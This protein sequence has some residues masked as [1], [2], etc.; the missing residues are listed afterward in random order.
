MHLPATPP[1]KRR[2]RER[3]SVPPSEM[4]LA[5]EPSYLEAG[6]TSWP[7]QI[8]SIDNHEKARLATRRRRRVPISA[9]STHADLES[10]SPTD[11]FGIV[12]YPIARATQGT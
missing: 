9:Q 4:E 1:T 5:G 6:S 8:R 2:T 7:R 12:S 10:T 3:E 11:H